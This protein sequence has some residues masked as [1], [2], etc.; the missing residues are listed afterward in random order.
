M[1]R[2]ASSPS[3]RLTPD[4]SAARRSRSAAEARTRF[5][6]SRQASTMR[7]AALIVSPI[8]AIPF[9][10]SPVRRQRPG[11]SEGRRGSRGRGRSR[12][13]NRTVARRSGRTRRSRRARS[14]PG[15]RPERAARSR[16]PSSP[17]YLW[18]SPPASA[19]AS[20]TSATKRLSRSRCATRRRARQSRS[21]RACP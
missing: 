21:R 14:R 17:T 10:R 19:T 4:G 6:V 11:R 9:F 12:A 8:S 2:K 3:L 5:S 13:H 15:S 16:S 20:D 7:A 18:I 1:P